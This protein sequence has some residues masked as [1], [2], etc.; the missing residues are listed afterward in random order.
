VQAINSIGAGPFTDPS[1]IVIP[2]G[3]PTAPQNVEVR[4]IE[5][6][7]EALISWSA[8]ERTNGADNE[9]Y[10][11]AE[12]SGRTDAAI[13]AASATSHR[14]ELAG[15]GEYVFTVV[16]TNSAGP[17]QAASAAVTVPEPP[18]SIAPVTG[19]DQIP[20]QGAPTDVSDPIQIQSLSDPEK[21]VLT[22][23]LGALLPG[24]LEITNEPV[25]VTTGSGQLQVEIP[26]QITGKQA[27]IADFNGF[28]IGVLSVE[29]EDGAPATAQ[30][31]LGNGIA[32]S[33]DVTVSSN[34]ERV[35]FS[36]SKM[37]LLLT[38]SLPP[39]T[40]DR[41]QRI[42]GSVL[43]TT[44]IDS[45]SEMPELSLLFLEEP[46]PPDFPSM[47]QIV[48]ALQADG[49]PI[50]TDEPG[51]DFALKI[52]HSGTGPLSPG[53]TTI[54]FTLIE[55]LEPGMLLIAT[56]QS[57][58]GVF[59]SRPVTCQSSP[60]EPP[61][62]SA[63]FDGSAG[64]FSTFAVLLAMPAAQPEQPTD[65]PAVPTA[66]TPNSEPTAAPVSSQD[67]DSTSED[68]SA[69][70]SQAVPVPVPTVRPEDPVTATESPPA[71]EPGGLS[72]LVVIVAVGSV[73][74]IAGLGGVGYFLNRRHNSTLPAFMLP[75]AGAAMLTLLVTTSDGQIANAAGLAADPV[76]GEG[77]IAQRSDLLR[78]LENL[79]GTGVTIGVISDSYGCDQD[80]LQSD[81]AQTAAAPWCKTFTT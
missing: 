61:S 76:G 65:T 46:G 3:P 41:E 54:S 70:G 34:A 35:T 6:S 72:S 56:K 64:G 15:T 78:S 73:F 29:S 11:I 63:I 57:D 2:A 25:T 58:D 10:L 80:A 51:V 60:D 77:D 1:E 14:I 40:T 67:N 49:W 31:D 5:G 33:G 68:I 44:Q 62:C 21:E 66:Q 17:G 50:L 28:S 39:T 81:I 12:A 30:V 24:G 4:L 7:A 43:F 23:Q 48:A 75:L 22:A 19:N 32:I 71:I 37:E 38:A 69:A 27:P 45:I 52:E 53:D 18:D 47:E 20:R 13:L 16:A 9:S 79:D 59:F 8:P 55:P 36:L 26:I 74:G 42:A